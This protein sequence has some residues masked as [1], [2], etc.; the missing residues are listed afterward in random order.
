ARG[1]LEPALAVA[2]VEADQGVEPPAAELLRE[3]ERDGHVLAELSLALRVTGQASIAGGHVARVEV[4]QGDVE[5]GLAD[6]RLDLVDR[7]GRPPEL[8][9]AQPGGGG[10]PEALEERRFLE[11]DRDVGGES[12]V[13]DNSVSWN[14]SSASRQHG[15]S[16]S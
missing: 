8:H 10:A 1:E 16:T 11:E 5:A 15:S 6:R 3:L 4:E 14:Y 2:L 13:L 9:G 7:L 12:H